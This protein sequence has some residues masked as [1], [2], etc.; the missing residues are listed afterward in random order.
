MSN[1]KNKVL[2]K[3]INCIRWQGPGLGKLGFLGA[4]SQPLIVIAP[5]SILTRGVRVPHMGEIWKGS[6]FFQWKTFEGRMSSCKSTAKQQE[7]VSLN[8]HPTEGNVIP[9]SCFLPRKITEKTTQRLTRTASMDPL[10]RETP[11]R[12][13]TAMRGR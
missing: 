10:V 1:N 5:R 2:G 7:L 9:L 8:I 11:R 13:R 12:V 4:W 6:C 3:S